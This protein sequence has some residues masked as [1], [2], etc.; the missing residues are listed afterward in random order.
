[1]LDRAD[2][3]EIRFARRVVHAD[4][5]LASAL[6]FV[7]SS[8]EG[9]DLNGFADRFDDP[10]EAVLGE[11]ARVLRELEG[12]GIPLETWGPWWSAW[13]RRTGLS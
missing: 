7:I 6:R 11:L 13:T 12:A 4:P 10:R 8:P 9:D 2:G 3:C 5:Q 1:M